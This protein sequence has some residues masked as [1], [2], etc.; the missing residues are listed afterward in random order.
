MPK[1]Y[2]I[3]KVAGTKKTFVIIV[4][5]FARDKLNITKDSKFKIYLDEEKK[6]IIYQLI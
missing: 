4:P 3:M 1:T 5:A 6:R 2:K